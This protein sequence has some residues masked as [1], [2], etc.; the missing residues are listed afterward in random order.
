MQRTTSIT[1]GDDLQAFIEQLITSGRYGSTSEVMRAAL[2]TL[3]EREARTAASWAYA[4]RQPTITDDE[5]DAPERAALDRIEAD[6]KN[7][8][9]EDPF[10]TTDEFRIELEKEG[11]L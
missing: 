5:L 8:L 3:A 1:L 4:D 6:R 7:G 11:F 10:L 9:P 2:R